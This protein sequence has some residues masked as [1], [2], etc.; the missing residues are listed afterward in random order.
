MKKILI[1]ACFALFGFG[2]YLAFERG[3]F[4]NFSF[5]G[6]GDKKISPLICD[7]NEKDCE[8]DFKG[9]KIFVEFGPKALQALEISKLRVF[10]LDEFDELEL[11]IYGL[12]MYMGDIWPR[13]VKN[14]GVFE[15]DVLLGACVLELMR[16]RAEFLQNGEPIGFYFDFDLKR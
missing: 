14:D 13:L 15:A 3:F 5:F 8:F 2:F 9:K 1:F 6:F 10:G 7:L 4:A 11:K 16:F 12:N